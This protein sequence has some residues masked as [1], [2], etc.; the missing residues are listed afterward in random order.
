MEA[1]GR[2]F[3]EAVDNS[4]SL[5]TG[6]RQEKLSDVGSPVGSYAALA[7][8]L[9]DDEQRADFERVVRSGM[10]NLLHNVMVLL[11]GGTAFTD[12][13]SLVFTVDGEELDPGLHELLIDFFDETGRATVY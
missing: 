9:R 3:D 6:R 11:D 1:V 8:A 13:H 12:S 4:V 10:T 7:R 2:A 5:A